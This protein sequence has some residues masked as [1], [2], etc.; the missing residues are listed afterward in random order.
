MAV[1]TARFAAVGDERRTILAE[2]GGDLVGFAHVVFDADPV[3]GALLDNLHVRPAEK[4]HGVGSRLVALVAEAVIER[5]SGLYLWVLAQNVDAQA[6]YKARGA[7]EVERALTPPPGG[8]ASR[9]NGS[10]VMMRYAW[11]APVVLV[12]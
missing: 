11:R 6:F 8:I 12:A 1:W 9:L 5:R 10:P 7:E 4:R 3:W 2:A